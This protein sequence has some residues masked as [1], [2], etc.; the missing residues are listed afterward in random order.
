[1]SCRL[2][3]LGAGLLFVACDEG[4]LSLS[5]Q[6]LDAPIARALL[7]LEETG[8]PSV[9]VLDLTTLVMSTTTTAPS[10]SFVYEFAVGAGDDDESSTL[11][12]IDA[13]YAFSPPED[14]DRS[15]LATVVDGDFVRVAGDDIAGAW[16]FYPVASSSRLWWVEV[17]D[18]AASIPTMVGLDRTTNETL[19]RRAFATEPS[20]SPDGSHLAW[21]DIDPASG[22]R[23]LMLGDAEGEKIRVLVSSP[24]TT[25][26]SGDLGLPTFSADGTTVYYVGLSA[27]IASWG[28]TVSALLIGTAHAHGSHDVAGDW[29]Q[30][31]VDGSRAPEQ[32][33]HLGTVH[34]DGVSDPGGQWLF[35][36]A[37]EGIYQVNVETGAAILVRAGRSYRAVATLSAHQ[38]GALRG[39]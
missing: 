7:V 36:A 28:E 18:A 9:N 10:R 8:P 29:W 22:A 37:R 31:P 3:I 24:T 30:V 6:R 32:L 20:L 34:Y 12:T 23:S 5:N 4:Q 16:A 17:D 35:I 11:G 33:T 38:L 2:L 27:Q 19:G 1:M 13:V 21:V 25:A 26:V 15:Y 39:E 14:F